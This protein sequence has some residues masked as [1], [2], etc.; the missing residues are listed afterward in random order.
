MFMS[1]MTKILLLNNLQVDIKRRLSAG[2]PNKNMFDDS[3]TRGTPLVWNIVNLTRITLRFLKTTNEMCFIST[4]RF[5][6]E[7][8]Y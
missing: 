7:A 2:F 5:L 3:A 8:G 6:D 1:A 4:D